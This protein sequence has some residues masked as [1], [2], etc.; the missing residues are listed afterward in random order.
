MLI[1]DLKKYGEC[2][3]ADTRP[4]IYFQSGIALTKICIEDLGLLW[5]A[6]TVQESLSDCSSLDETEFNMGAGAGC[7][8]SYER[9]QA[10]IARCHDI[11]SKTRP[12]LRTFAVTAEPEV[13]ARR[14][15]IVQWSGSSTAHLCNKKND[16][17]FRLL[18]SR[19]KGYQ[20]VKTEEL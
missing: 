16:I 14:D 13:R 4:H 2:T 18:T 19:R 11:S 9:M 8:M 3:G 20:A 6:D 7:S 15:A 1:P 17:R 10:I 12:K 5:S